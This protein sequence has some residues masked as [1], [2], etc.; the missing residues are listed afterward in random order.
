MFG[1]EY[2]DQLSR[3]E[4]LSDEI[5]GISGIPKPKSELEVLAFLEVALRRSRGGSGGLSR[6]EAVAWRCWAPLR[7][8]R[9]RRQL[10]IHRE[11]LQA[12][13][14]DNPA[15]VDSL[16]QLDDL[17]FARTF[18]RAV[19]AP[20]KKQVRNWVAKGLLSREDAAALVLN[21]CLYCDNDG[22]LCV[23]DDRLLWPTGILYV[24]LVGANSTLLIAWLLLSPAPLLWG[25]AG[26]AIVGGLFGGAWWVFLRYFWYPHKLIPRLRKLLPRLKSV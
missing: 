20:I 6:I 22:R 25:V 8:F 19:E 21:R 24:V 3:L 14:R 5:L 17:I 11:I 9:I 4:M 18:G 7:D 23:V 26:S 12:F 10:Q 13:G 15:T 2:N 16:S 1:R